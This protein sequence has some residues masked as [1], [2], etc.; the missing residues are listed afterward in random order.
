MVLEQELFLIGL[1]L[2]LSFF[3]SG[4]E[5]AYL[6]VDKLSVVLKKEQGRWS[7]R[8]IDKFIQN[9]SYFLSMVLV[10][11]T[12][13]LVLY[14]Y[15]MASFSEP[16]FVQ[17]L[18]HVW[19]AD[20]W[21]FFLQA[22]FSTS[23]VLIVSEFIPK[24]IFRL[25]PNFL[26][27]LLF[28]FILVFYHLLWPIVYVVS[29]CSVFF[30][31]RVLRLPY[32]EKRTIFGV[33]DL[34][35]YLKDFRRNDTEPHEG[36]DTTHV[37][38]NALEFKKVKVRETMVPRTEMVAVDRTDGTE[39][40]KNAFV[41]SGHSRILVYEGDIDH[42]V[43]YCHASEWFKP[44]A[45]H[46]Q[47]V[48]PELVPVPIINEVILAKDLMIQ[49]IKESKNLALVVDEYGGTSGLITI[50]DIIE[51]IFGEIHDEHD[52][53]NRV[54]EKIAPNEYLFSARLEVKY[55]NQKYLFQLPEGDYET[56]GGMLLAHSKDIPKPK[57]IVQVAQYRIKVLSRDKNRIDK[58]K[59]YDEDKEE[60]A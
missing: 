26:L 58:V 1:G 37:L 13:S 5:M 32:E 41:N 44:Q 50:E 25:K 17:F 56:L 42:V 10:G 22:L 27:S 3:F 18:G 6:S 34:G 11:N 46:K 28:P 30:I 7:A 47:S 14:S 55:L 12:L 19:Q 16:Y 2:V 45:Q 49:L 48:Y 29:G 36:L 31:R 21:I 20:V 24:N 23:V 40:L 57:D 59:L 38:S 8:G 43:G 60:E 33:L 39:A 54:E 52:E 4:I 53:H 35:N 51:K 9:P 15:A